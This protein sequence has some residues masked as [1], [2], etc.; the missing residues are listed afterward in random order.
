LLKKLEELLRQERKQVTEDLKRR[1]EQLLDTKET[2]AIELDSLKKKHKEEL[3]KLRTDHSVRY[4]SFE[5]DFLD[6]MERL[7][8][9]IELLENEKENMVGPNQ[10]ISEC[11]SSRSDS[12]AGSRQLSELESDLECC[13][14]SYIC[15]PPCKIY[16]CPEGD[17]LCEYCSQEKTRRFCPKCGISLAGALSRNKGLEKIAAKY[18]A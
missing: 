4:T 18:Y 16:Q 5:N 14:C 2:N 17:L 6:E 13:S 3:K 7:K 15:R 8:K 1:K 9:D 11:L 10:L 12:S